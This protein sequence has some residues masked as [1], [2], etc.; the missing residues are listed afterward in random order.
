LTIWLLE[1]APTLQRALG[2]WP[3]STTAVDLSG[4]SV[5]VKRAP[6]TAH[7]ALQK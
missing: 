6:E 5:L 3:L 2:F 7:Q 4:R 1:M